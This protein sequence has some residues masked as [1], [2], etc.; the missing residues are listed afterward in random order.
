MRKLAFVL[1]AGFYG[2]G[3]V[4]PAFAQGNAG[5]GSIKINKN[6]LDRV[7]WYEAPREY[8]IINDGPN[9]VDRRV[10][11]Q[12]PDSLQVNIPPLPAAQ[13]KQYVYGSPAGGGSG[14][15]AI[16]IAPQTNNLPAAGFQQNANRVQH[17]NGLPQASSVPV[18]GGATPAMPARGSSSTKLVNATMKP[19]S[20]QAPKALSYGPSYTGA[21]AQTTSVQTQALGKIIPARNPHPLLNHLNGSN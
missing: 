17:I 21:S 1:L 5:G 12:A 18:V 9:V 7:K 14:E 11:D 6:H 3:F 15:Q 4:T 10:P 20:A 19:N 8:Q 2:V 13:G 16:R